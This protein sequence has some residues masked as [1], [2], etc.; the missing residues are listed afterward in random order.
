MRIRITPGGTVAIVLMLGWMP[1]FVPTV[2]AQ[3]GKPGN[4]EL[5]AIRLV[6]AYP[7]LSF[8]RPVW[9]TH[10]PGDDSRQFVVEQAGR[11]LV[12]PNRANV[13]KPKVFLD[14]REKV[15]SYARGFHNEEGMLCLAFH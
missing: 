6:P 1:G 14:L 8:D 4:R 10:P 12:F 11:I 7:Q 9:M 15:R 5:P 13:F 2:V 3:S